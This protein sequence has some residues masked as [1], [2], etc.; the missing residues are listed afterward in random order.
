MPPVQTTASDVDEI[1]VE[2]VVEDVNVEETVKVV[3]SVVAML[4]VVIVEG[5]AVKVLVVE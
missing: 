5:K 3:V 4:E 2:V 1:K